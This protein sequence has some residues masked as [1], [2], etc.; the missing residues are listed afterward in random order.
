MSYVNYV[1]SRKSYTLLPTR[2]L[3]LASFVLAACC[4]A[5]HW[6]AVIT[7]MDPLTPYGVL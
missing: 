7:T 1:Q 3:R 4:Q 5:A 2:S 6:L